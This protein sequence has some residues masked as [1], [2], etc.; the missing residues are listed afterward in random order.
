MSY[1]NDKEE[2]RC[3]AMIF[4]FSA[5]GNSKY[6]AERIAAAIDDHLISLRDAVRTRTYK[7]DVSNETRIGFVVPTYFFGLPS[8]L[9][10]FLNKLELTG[11]Q[12]QFVY[13]VLTCGS[14]TGDAAG[15]MAKALAEK[16]ITLSAQFAVPMVDNYIPMYKIVEKEEI[17]K[18]LDA[19][20]EYID[21]ARRAIRACSSGNYNRSR[22]AAPAAMTA[23]AYPMYASRRSTKP[24]VV[25]DACIGC[26][27]CQE[28][29]ACGAIELIEGK[30]TWK[31]SRCVQCLACIH[32]CPSQ[33]I[34]WKKPA[35]NQGRYY[36][37]RV[38]P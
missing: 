23:V 38:E 28:I 16:E 29:C 24:F 32:R 26:G 22:G 8:I 9:Q 1:D 6:V 33:A 12:N 13:L 7:Y 19:A 25:T 18:K 31:K 4:F 17:E 11:Y 37:P 21:E 2:E 27:L 14:A 20:E 35:E 10:F 36:N 34:H 3:F 30:P 15:Q 5:T